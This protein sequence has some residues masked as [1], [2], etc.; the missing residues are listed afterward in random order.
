MAVS[1]P[2]GRVEAGEAPQEA[3]RRE[4]E[5]EA[6][7]RASRLVKLAELHEVP[8]F[9]RSVGHLYAAEG[10]EPVPTRR[11]DGELTMK[12]QRYSEAELQGMVRQGAIRSVTVVAAFHHFLAHRTAQRRQR[13]VC[14]VAGLMLCAAAVGALAGGLLGRPARGR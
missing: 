4:L 13:R 1:S 10:L 5:E 3:A 2:A 6:G 12:V 11:D 7:L 14:A 9:A 8:E